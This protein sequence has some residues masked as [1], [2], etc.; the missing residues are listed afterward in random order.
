MAT[1][2]WTNKF[3]NGAKFGRSGFDTFRSL[4]TETVNVSESSLKRFELI[5]TET[6]NASES[7]NK[8]LTMNFT[9]A[10]EVSEVS[11]QGKLPS[12]KILNVFPDQFDVK[13]WLDIE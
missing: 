11:T 1:Q 5:F 12:P 4:S 7:L 3:D 6:I 13:V 2:V 9:E 8:N 10:I